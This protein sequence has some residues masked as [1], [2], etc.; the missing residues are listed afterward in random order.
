MHRYFYYL[1]Y[2]II[3]HTAQT[4]TFTDLMDVHEVLLPN[5][6]LVGIFDWSMGHAKYQ[7]DALVFEYP[8]N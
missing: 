6:Q 3:L 1:L 2:V 8:T 5:V 7:S 4:H